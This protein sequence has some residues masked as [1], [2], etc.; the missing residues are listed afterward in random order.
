MKKG[1]LG[2]LLCMLLG[3]LSGCQA[4]EKGSTGYLVYYISD[5]GTRLAEEL[6]IP[7]ADTTKTIAEQLL[8]KM[9]TPSVGLDAKEALPEYV[10]I[11]DCHLAEGTITINF[12]KEYYEMEAVREILVR[13]AFVKTLVQVPQINQVMITVE[14]E[15]FVDKSGEEI[16]ALNAASFIDTKGDAINSYQYASLSLYFASEDGTKIVREM[17]NVHYSSNS[18]LEKV[19]IEQ[20]I[21]GPMNSKLQP[22]VA[23]NAKLLGISVLDG[24]CTLNFDGNFNQAPEN[25]NVTAQAAVYAIVNALFDVCHVDGV[26]IQ[27]E[28]TTEVSYR[29][30]FNLNEPMV[31]NAEIILPAAPEEGTLLEPLVGVESFFRN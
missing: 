30:E 31:R 4:E 29:G 16:G 10:S 8:E 26:V 20:L 21:K 1:I 22:V 25:S 28:G 27:I 13:A 5:T 9:Q 7:T 3:L 11:L 12:S 14:G 6:Y 15:A 24:I 2:I 18:T 23:A 19:V 17:R